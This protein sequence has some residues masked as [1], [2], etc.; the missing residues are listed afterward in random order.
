MFLSCML[1]RKIHFME[2]AKLLR[3]CFLIFLLL[4]MRFR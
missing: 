3:N 4:F 2:K 1:K